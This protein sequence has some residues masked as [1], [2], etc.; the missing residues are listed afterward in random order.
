MSKSLFLLPLLWRGKQETNFIPVRQKKFWD[1][2]TWLWDQ[3][4]R[5]ETSWK[6]QKL[7]AEI[8]NIMV[9]SYTV[10]P[11]SWPFSY[12]SLTC[13]PFP[14]PSC[15]C[16]IRATTGSETSTCNVL[17][18]SGMSEDGSR[19][20]TRIAGKDFGPDTTAWGAHVFPLYRR[21]LTLVK[22]L[23]L[24]ICITCK[25]QVIILC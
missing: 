11:Y 9:P 6:F 4:T 17:I 12:A 14:P 5:K 13:L 1:Q 19:A 2:P 22:V 10:P 18:L 24:R 21:T 7:D 23:S 3:I 16:G 15:P 25:C 8:G 20:L